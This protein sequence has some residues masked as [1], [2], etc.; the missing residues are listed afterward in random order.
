MWKS[1]FP[2]KVSHYDFQISLRITYFKDI[3]LFLAGFFLC[4]SSVFLKTA[5]LLI[6]PASGIQY[7]VS[8][9]PATINPGNCRKSNQ[10]KLYNR[11][12]TIV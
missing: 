6:N 1:D 5:K 12:D 8:R 9:R 3:S 11:Q 7:Q 4:L 2:K 10:Q